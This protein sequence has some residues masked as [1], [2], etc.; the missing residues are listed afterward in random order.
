MAETPEAFVLY[1]YN[2][3]LA[4]A[5]IFILL[6]LTST[7]FHAFQLFRNRTW[8]F[9]PFFIGGVFEALGYVGRA[10]SA[11]QSP[12]WTTGPYIVQSLLL[13]LAPTLFAASIYMILGRIIRLTDGEEHSLIRAKWLTKVFV[14]GD[15]L[16][17]FT[18]SGGGGM[19]ASAKTQSS[20][21]L[22]QKIITAGL[23]LQVLFFGF[24]IIVA[25]IF[26]MK[27][28]KNPTP[29]S[30]VV[31]V[32]WQKYLLILYVASF[33]IMIRSIFRIAE[34]VQGNDGALLKTETYL[35]IFDAALMFLAMLLFNIFHPSKII[36]K[37]TLKSGGWTGDSSYG[38]SN[39]VGLSSRENV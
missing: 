3:S 17:F 32:P 29:R 7:L 37:N 21:N 16:S 24:F 35:Y 11:K 38:Y 27:I 26:H 5:V 10:A 34:Y 36:S 13:L 23:F 33:F 39:S 18:Q 31:Q 20:V 8:Y 1:H 2:P 6:F 15:V 9:I 19:M 4:A 25:S 30:M 28:S 12:N 14:A 22:G